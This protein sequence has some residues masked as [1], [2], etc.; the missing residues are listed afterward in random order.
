MFTPEGQLADKI[1]KIMLLAMWTKT[2]HTEKTLAVNALNELRKII[3][4]GM[5]QPTYPVNMH[6]I[7]HYLHYWQTIEKLVLKAQENLEQIQESAAIDYGHPQGDENARKIM[8]TAMSSWYES[9]IKPDHILF[10]TGGA[11]GLRVVFETL[12]ELYKNTPKYRIIT[13]FPYYSLYADYEAHR[14]HPINVM[15]EPGYKLTAEALERSISEAYEL[16]KIDQGKPK[17]VLIC[18]PNNPLGT[19]ISEDELIKIAQV[20]KKYP[21][22][23][24]IIDEAYAEMAYEKAPSLLKIAPYLKDRMLVMRSGTKGLSVAGERLAVLMAFDKVMMSKLVTKN[25]SLTGHAPISAQKAYAETMKNLSNEDLAALKKFYKKKVDYVAERLNTMGAGMPDPN[26]KVEGAFY[27]LADFS[28]MLGLSLPEQAK[29]ALGKT[30]E[31][32][33]DEELAYALLFEDDLMIAPL[34]Y[35]GM[36]GD[37]GFMRITCSRNLDELKELMDRLEN[38]LLVARKVKKKN[39]EDMIAQLSLEFTTSKTTQFTQRLDVMKGDKENC[40]TLKKHNMILKDLLSEMQR[41][42]KQKKLD[43]Q[44]KA[45]PTLQ[46]FFKE[47]SQHKREDF[48]QQREIDREWSEF[49]ATMFSESCETKTLFLNL[50]EAERNKFIPW[51]KHLEDLDKAKR[52]ELS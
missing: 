4:A 39:L 49:I 36:P 34:S 50:P 8:A 24:V 20:L 52:Q 37:K 1:D 43:E 38:R 13:P 45:P 31:I 5:G 29:R 28:D 15:N 12:H 42:L 19:V 10:L 23:H 33:T 2:L 16:A 6:T 51:Q 35:F 11:G 30:G 44:E 14:L 22:L 17:A 25:I 41:A 47:E 48:N 7:N 18:N 46:S 3:F 9:E 27:V 21:D 32:K 26:Y 40:I